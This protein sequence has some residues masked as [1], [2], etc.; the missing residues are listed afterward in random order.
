MALNSAS[1]FPICLYFSLE[2][3]TKFKELF[4]A[5]KINTQ[6]INN[7]K[8]RGVKNTKFIKASAV[9]EQGETFLLQN[10]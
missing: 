10:T 9:N 8:P 2:F 4:L 6:N 1:T 7:I 5:K 3:R